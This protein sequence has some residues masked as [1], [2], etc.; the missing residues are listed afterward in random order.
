MFKKLQRA[1]VSTGQILRI[2]S[3]NFNIFVRLNESAVAALIDTGATVS[4][5]DESYVDPNVITSSSFVKL[6]GANNASLLVLG[7]ASVHFKW[8]E[9]LFQ[10]KFYVIRH[11]LV[12][13]ILGMDFLVQN[14]ALLDC[15]NKTLKINAVEFFSKPDLSKETVN[16]YVNADD[17]KAGSAKI[18]PV[19][20]T[21]KSGA[22]PI[23]Q[24]IRRKTVTEKE[25]IDKEVNK[26]LSM[27]VIRPSFSPWAS[28]IQLTTKKNNEIRFCIDFRKVNENIV[29]DAYPMPFIADIVDALEGSKI[30]S[31]IDLT[32]GYW[33]LP[34]G[35]ESKSITAFST[36]EGL[37][38]FNVLPFGLST[39]SAIFQRV[40]NGIFKDVEFVRVYMDDIIIFSQND[41]EHRDHLEKTF[42]ILK[43]AGLAVNMKKCHFFKTEINFLGVKIDQDGV[44][45]NSEK[46]DAILKITPPKDKKSLQQFLGVVNYYRDFCPDLAE[47]S[48]CLYRLLKKEVPF[49]WTEEHEKAFNRIKELLTSPPVLGIAKKGAPF[50][51]STD[52]SQAALGAV[53]SQVIEGREVPIAY[54]S[55]ALSETEQR[56]A[57]VEKELLA[58]VFGVKRFRCYLMGNKFTVTT[59]HNPLQYL[60][61]LKDPHGRLARWTM[62]L[63]EFDFEVK[64]KAGKLNGNADCLSRCMAVQEDADYEKLLINGIIPVNSEYYPM[65]HSIYVDGDALWIRSAKGKRRVLPR[66]KR[67][68]TIC[69]THQMGHFGIKK[70]FA[71]LQTLFWWPRMFKDVQQYVQECETCQKRNS[72]VH[73]CV[74]GA[75]FIATHPMELLCWDIMGPLPP[76]RTGNK[77]ILVIVD[78]FSRYAEAF[79][80]KDATSETLAEI[81]WREFMCRYGIPKRIHS[82]QGRNFNAVVLKRVFEFWN[83]KHST[84]VPYFPQSNGIVERLNKTIQDI[85]SKTL[86]KK[87]MGSWDAHLPAAM[88]AY[89]VI[90]HGETGVAP[91][92][93]FFG[94]LARWPASFNQE[95]DFIQTDKEKFKVIKK[96]FD[97]TTAKMQRSTRNLDFEVG[98]SVFIYRPQVSGDMPKKFS[99]PWKGPYSVIAK[100][101]FLRYLVQDSTGNIFETHAAQ[102]KKHKM[103]SEVEEDTQLDDSRASTTRRYGLRP[104]IFKPRRLI[105]G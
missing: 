94:R 11:L 10:Q 47:N 22:K 9:K 3:P 67:E 98:S 99:L 51:L 105:E 59:D 23:K 95:L 1:G 50:I 73:R 57:V 56:Y 71:L 17:F 43:K 69:E 72:P 66:G 21:I 88:Y 76:S 41:L 102:M 42:S 6:K 52:A 46:I 20:I 82:D 29:G 5:L 97:N 40:M 91:Y 87:E 25:V 81:L 70:T 85:I 49:T 74:T 48:T 104:M 77:Y 15:A 90:P 61:S 68:E 2:D 65:R 31:T 101:G 32:K 33:Q 13:M 14:N 27:N 44:H 26:M 39:A 84:S 60:S 12:P 34:L 24:S 16:S 78:V 18:P 19:K 37:F 54:A 38:E 89:N 28:P 30:F 4:C 86:D 7:T 58:I 75:S 92:T 93:L 79:P 100:K 62:L 80:M 36:A 45:P 96:M 8:N 103:A 35:E 55:R 63:Q 64:Y 53:L 83:I